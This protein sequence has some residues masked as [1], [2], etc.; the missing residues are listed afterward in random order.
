MDRAEV[1]AGRLKALRLAM[2][3]DQAK[4]WCAF[5]GIPENAWNHFERGRRYHCL[6]TRSNSAPRPACRSTGS[7]AASITPCRCTSPKRSARL[8]PRTRH[9]IAAASIRP[10]SPK[11]FFYTFMKSEP[12]NRQARPQT[13]DFRPPPP[14]GL[15][16]RGTR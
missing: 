14:F 1:I 4:T 2:G 13:V 16:P 9:D 3:F 8:L 6:P 12:T 5:V 11:P 15:G 10:R 7:I